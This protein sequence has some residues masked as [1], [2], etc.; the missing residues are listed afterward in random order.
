MSVVQARIGY[1]NIPYERRDCVVLW[2]SVVQARIGYCNILFIAFQ[3]KLRCVSRSGA[4]RLLQQR[5]PPGMMSAGAVSVVQ[6]RIGYCN[7]AP[8]CRA[9][10]E[11][12]CQSF[13]RE[14]ATATPSRSSHEAQ[15]EGVS[16]SGAN[17][18]LQH[19]HNKKRR[20]HERVS[21][22]QA[23]IG[24]CNTASLNGSTFTQRCQSF[25]RE[26]ATATDI[27][28]K[29]Y[30]GNPGV[31]RSGANRL[32]Q[33]PPNSSCAASA[34]CQSFR[35]ES[36]TAT[37][38]QLRLRQRLGG[39]SRSGANRLLQLNVVGWHPH[40]VIV[41]VVQARIGYC[42]PPLRKCLPINVLQAYFR[43]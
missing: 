30:R 20:H 22:V 41:S 19:N 2:V 35:R 5:R 17:R 23:R 26:S 21:V 29:N 16:R 27:R 34:P 39:V 37:E 43:A 7:D 40:L 13:R 10:H 8:L 15:P 36:A 31:S 42:N 3:L 28:A 38:A 4:N 25:R 33:Q 9:P 32:L 6:A 18:L 24:Y 12:T 11:R 1:C 14:S